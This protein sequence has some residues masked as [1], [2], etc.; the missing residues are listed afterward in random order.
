[1]LSLAQEDT[2]VYKAR[3]SEKDHFNSSGQRLNT[4]MA[5]LRQDRANFHTFNI[6]DVEDES[7]EM[8]KNKEVRADME[9]M[10]VS[11]SKATEKAILNGTPVI[12]M[13]VFGDGGAEITLVTENQVINKA[14]VPEK[15][16]VSENEIATATEKD[17]PFKM[18][19]SCKKE[20]EN[21][22]ISLR[23][24][25]HDHY[26][27]DYKN[28]N[29]FILEKNFSK[30]VGEL[31]YKQGH[32]IFDNQ[33]YEIEAKSITEISIGKDELGLQRGSGSLFL[34][35]GCYYVNIY[36]AFKDNPEFSPGGRWVFSDNIDN[37]NKLKNKLLSI[38]KNIQV[39][40]Q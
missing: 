20:M 40:G 39:N 22:S 5:I 25:T 1:M 15:R 19:F 10:V 7:D 30:K 11:I 12:Q 3:L 24:I 8:F 27:V 16:A 26:D 23:L 29:L 31:E 2:L 9:K 34:L 14:V 38:N 6:K 13:E 18:E 33:N 36:G 37:L 32:G 4:A 35:D 21:K 28:G 17:M